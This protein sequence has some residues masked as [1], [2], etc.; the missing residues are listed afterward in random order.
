MTINLKSDGT[1]RLGRPPGPSA[2]RG[3]RPWDESNF[4][5]LK[6]VAANLDL[7]RWKIAAALGMSSSR[8]SNIT[9][10]PMGTSILER[11]N[12]MKGQLDAY[13]LPLD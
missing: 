6:F 7:P 8:L 9:C 11:L 12:G 5:V 13:R 1:S 10:S 4:E 2:D 3:P